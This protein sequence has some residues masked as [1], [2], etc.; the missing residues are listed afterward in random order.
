[1]PT[2]ILRLGLG[3]GEEMQS[4][5]REAFVP[6][7]TRWK[8]SLGADPASTHHGLAF[9]PCS[10]GLRL[11]RDRAAQTPRVLS[12]PNALGHFP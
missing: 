11:L 7:A 4:G 5:L 3:I 6:N 12:V 1:M 10:A 2:E 9:P 8:Q